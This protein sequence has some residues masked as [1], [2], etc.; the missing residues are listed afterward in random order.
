MEESRAGYRVGVD[1]GGTV[2]VG[3][4]GWIMGIE[5]EG[6]TEATRNET[7]DLAVNVAG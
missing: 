3:R 2:T 1:V 7:G 4:P 6:G 5:V